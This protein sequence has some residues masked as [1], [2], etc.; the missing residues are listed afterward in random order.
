MNYA[1]EI[2]YWYLRFNGF[3][4]LINFVIHRSKLEASDGEF[5]EKV[6]VADRR[7]PSDCDVLAIRTPWVYEEIGGLPGDWDGELF[8]FFDST[9]TVGVICEVKAGGYVEKELF[10]DQYVK[11]SL[12]RLGFQQEINKEHLLELN[13]TGSVMLGNSHQVIK[14][15][16]SNT[17]PKSTETFRYISITNGQNF[18]KERFINYR[19]KR[20]DWVYF[21]SSLLQQMVWNIK[22]ERGEI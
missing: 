14:L 9:R 4:P 5:V 3:F 15:F 7:Y 17:A 12:Q 19:E 20:S 13:T 8:S 11:Y 6:A 21:K 16:I 1:E 10:Q 18:I 2:A 22:S